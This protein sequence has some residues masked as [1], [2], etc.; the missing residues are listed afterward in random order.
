MEVTVGTYGEGDCL[1][2]NDARVYPSPCSKSLSYI[3]YKK[4]ENRTMNE[5]GTFDDSK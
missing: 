2:M 3:C 4:A 5:C 1:S